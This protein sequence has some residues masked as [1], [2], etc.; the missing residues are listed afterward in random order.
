MIFKNTKF[1]V[2]SHQI[3]VTF[4]LAIIPLGDINVPDEISVSSFLDASTKSFHLVAGSNFYNHL[5]IRKKNIA[6]KEVFN[7]LLAP[8]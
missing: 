2:K 7:D 1:K 3:R 6:K 5:K 8:R 4:K